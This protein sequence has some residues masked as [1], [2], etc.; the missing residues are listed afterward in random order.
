MKHSISMKKILADT[1]LAG[2]LSLTL[3]ASQAMASFVDYDHSAEGVH[4]S[5]S[6]YTGTSMKIGGFIDHDHS[7][8]GVSTGNMAPSGKKAPGMCGFIDCDHRS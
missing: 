8:E 4:K 7:A 5:A 3:V 6:V 1:A 2:A